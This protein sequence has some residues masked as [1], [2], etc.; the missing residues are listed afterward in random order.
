[1]EPLKSKASESEDKSEHFVGTESATPSRS[2]KLNAASIER[3][4]KIVLE[5]NKILERHNNDRTRAAA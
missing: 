4:V 5:N 1:M 2:S 3:L